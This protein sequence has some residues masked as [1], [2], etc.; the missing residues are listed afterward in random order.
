MPFSTGALTL[1]FLHD[2]PLS[3]TYPTRPYWGI[4]C[5]KS[6]PKH[7][8]FAKREKRLFRP[9]PSGQRGKKAELAGLRFRQN[10]GHGRSG[11]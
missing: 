6:N 10:R 5:Q 9:L 8:S 2:V 11:S 3:S 7:R 1:R 4:A